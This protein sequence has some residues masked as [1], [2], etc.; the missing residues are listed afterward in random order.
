MLKVNNIIPLWRVVIPN[1]SKPDFL[2]SLHIQLFVNF[3][4]LKNQFPPHCFPFSRTDFT[5][6][7]RF[8]DVFL[9]GT[10]SFWRIWF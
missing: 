4:H 1:I 9:M 3:F 10:V 7:D 6:N 5:F 8:T 2:R